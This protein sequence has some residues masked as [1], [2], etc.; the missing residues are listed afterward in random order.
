M[1]EWNRKK[2]KSGTALY[3]RVGDALEIQGEYNR[4]GKSMQQEILLDLGLEVD[5]SKVGAK[6]IGIKAEQYWVDHITKEKTYKNF[7]E[8]LV[9]KLLSKP[10]VIIKTERITTSYANGAIPEASLNPK[11]IRT[12]YQVIFPVK[13][14]IYD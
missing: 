14:R 12:L 7:F 8:F 9:K 10:T 5:F 11:L 13:E 1:S 6:E 3:R 4:K 2:S